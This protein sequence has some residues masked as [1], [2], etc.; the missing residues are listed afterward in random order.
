MEAHVSENQA[1]RWYW[2]HIDSLWVDEAY[3]GRGVGA[4][5]MRHAEELANKPAGWS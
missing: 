3:R 4:A 1:P 5:L 2:L